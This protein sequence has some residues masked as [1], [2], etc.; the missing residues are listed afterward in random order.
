MLIACACVSPFRCTRTAPREPGQEDRRAHGVPSHRK[1]RVHLLKP[2]L[3][4]DQNGK[5]KRSAGRFAKKGR[6]E[7][8]ERSTHVRF[9]VQML[10]IATERLSDRDLSNN[11]LQ[12]Q[13]SSS[14]S[15]YGASFRQASFTV[16]ASHEVK[17]RGNNTEELPTLVAKRLEALGM[18]SSHL[19]VQP[20]LLKAYLVA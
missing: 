1:E 20:P 19:L 10:H 2:R 12:A 5:T 9:H 13:K 8:M 6:E 15:R 11:Q 16:R 14:F 17:P 4:M 7:T 3:N 18:R